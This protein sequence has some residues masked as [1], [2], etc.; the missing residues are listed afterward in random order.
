MDDL[1]HQTLIEHITFQI[2]FENNYIKYY[3]IFEEQFTLI[4]DFRAS[5]N[6]LFIS[7]SLM[8]RTLFNISSS[9][10]NNFFSIN[11]FFKA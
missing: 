11:S 8:V 6:S 9:S 10:L 2:G 1:F 5:Y 4:N 7:H 3:V